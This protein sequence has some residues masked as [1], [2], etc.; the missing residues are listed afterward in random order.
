VNEETGVTTIHYQGKLYNMSGY[1][2]D[3]EKAAADIAEQI[4][5]SYSGTLED[6]TVVEVDVDLTVAES[7]S[8]VN[9]SD[10][11][12]VITNLKGGKGWTPILGHKTAYLDS[13]SFRPTISR[14]LSWFGKN[15]ARSAAHEVGHQMGLDHLKRP[16]NLM[17]S[18]GWGTHINRGQRGA[19]IENI[20]RGSLNVGSNSYS[21]ARGIRLPYPRAE[22]RYR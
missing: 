13:R 15:N 20:D 14:P 18:P 22:S 19:I 16:F 11:L 9:E 10:H 1:D 7:M 21:P 17:K 3:M 6:G 4:I 12:L 5:G 8:D 2:I